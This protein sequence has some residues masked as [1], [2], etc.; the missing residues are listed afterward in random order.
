MR[1]DAISPTRAIDQSARPT[2]LQRHNQFYFSAPAS[3]K[4]PS[5]PR[6]RRQFSQ[7]SA[8]REKSFVEA[9]SAIHLVVISRGNPVVSTSIHTRHRRRLFERRLY[10]LARSR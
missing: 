2:F 4:R 5:A 9:G 8:A 1:R 10:T 6:D 7:V 3:E